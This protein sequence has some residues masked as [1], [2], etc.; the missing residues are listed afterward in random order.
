M[1]LLFDSYYSCSY[2]NIGKGIRSISSTGIITIVSA[3]SSIS[4]TTTTASTTTHNHK[5]ASTTTTNERPADYYYQYAQHLINVDL[6]LA[7]FF[8]FLVITRDHVSFERRH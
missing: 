5:K 1:L 8:I 7:N 2:I 6:M 4:I 3:R